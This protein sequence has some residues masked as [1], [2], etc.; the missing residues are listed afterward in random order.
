MGKRNSKESEELLAEIIELLFMGYSRKQIIQ[1]C[2]EKHNIQDRQVDNY[3]AKAYKKVSINIKDYTSQLLQQSIKRFNE[4]YDKNMTIQDYRECRQVQESIIKM[5]LSD[6]GNTD[7]PNERQKL[8]KVK[9][10]ITID[11]PK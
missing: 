11:K 2:A 5:F 4:L 6:A 9:Y 3:L 8:P 10:S 7:D 1:F